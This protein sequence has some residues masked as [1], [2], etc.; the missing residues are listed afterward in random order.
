MSR[1]PR[2]L[3]APTPVTKPNH[4]LLLPPG[5]SVQ[6]AI[7]AICKASHPAWVDIAQRRRWL[8]C[9]ASTQQGEARQRAAVQEAAASI[10]FA[11]E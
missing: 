1:R 5:S 8:E 9:I 4:T 11:F 3:S 10:G 2:V 6:A 7:D